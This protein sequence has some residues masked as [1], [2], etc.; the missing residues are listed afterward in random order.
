MK[1]TVHHREIP[2]LETV[3]TKP[4]EELEKQI[5]ANQPAIEAW[6]RENWSCWDNV[7]L[8]CSV[9][10]RNSG[11]KVA[12]VDTN[13]FPAGFN[14][15]N[16][17][18]LP[19][20]VQA[21]QYAMGKYF[22]SCRRILIVS[23]NYNRNKAYFLSLHQLQQI[24]SIAGYEVKVGR[25]DENYIDSEVQT[26]LGALEINSINKI[27]DRLVTNGFDPCIV[28]LNRDLSEGIPPELHG[29]SQI[30]TPIPE[31]GWARRFK[32][33]HF[34]YYQD[35]CD[36]FAKEFNIDV[37]RISPLFRQCKNVD[38]LKAEGLQE[39]ASIV[40]ELL[41]EIQ[42]K[43]QQH[44][45]NHKPFV[46]VKSDSG[47]Y[48]MGVMMIDSS[49]KILNMNRKQR[50]KMST[51]KGR[52]SI[53]QVI[54]QEGIYSFE[55]YEEAVAEPV[56]YLIGHSV[57]GGFYRIHKSKG[58]AENLNSPGMEFKP[59]AFSD[60]CNTPDTHSKTN[61]FYIYGVIARLALLAAV[62]EINQVC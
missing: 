6:F 23:E 51:S 30:V 38:F 12:A 14:N 58:I 62:R 32:S 13:L 20:Y 5:L 43:Y 52:Q 11:F 50:V 19:L 22:P 47:T 4:I 46:V 3:N 61:R 44:S 7:P 9:D 21:A 42:L 15:L 60:P 16:S 33:I 18:L 24:F 54:V 45:I 41:D 10:L 28:F 1:T 27:N 56:V 29:L 49:D 57:V 36:E 53:N 2:H 34:E 8:T 25:L 39:L 40:D 48:G 31:M 55:D 17:D 26:E 59:L 37:W 35:V